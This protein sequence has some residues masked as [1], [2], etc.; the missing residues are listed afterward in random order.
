MSKA[1][2]PKRS[3]PFT[4]RQRRTWVL[5]IVDQEPI[6]H[7]ALAAYRR[8]GERV[9]E[10]RETVER[11]Q[12]RERPAFGSWL[13]ATFGA[14]LTEL[15][16]TEARIHQQGPL[17]DAI[18]FTAL[19][20]GCSPGEAYDEVMRDK[21]AHERRM[22]RQ[23][24]GEPPEEQAEADEA[25]E[26]FGPDD[27]FVELE[28]ELTRMFG[29]APPQANSKQ[30]PPDDPVPPGKP[31]GAKGRRKFS[32][33]VLDPTPEQDTAERRLKAAYRAVV[34]QLHP[35]LRSE[36]NEYEMQLWHDAQ[37][38]Y[39]RGDAEHLE[40]ILAVSELAATGTLPVGIGLGGLLGLVRQREASIQKLE[41][42]VRGLKKDPAW[43]FTRLASQEKLARRVGNRLRQD[44]AAARADLAAIEADLERCRQAPRRPK[45][46]SSRRRKTPP[47]SKRKGRR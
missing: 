23:A 13:A 16:E 33:P 9:Q 30:K 35:D 27:P 15:R 34:R 19:F 5:V 26:D 1:K 10:L 40:T 2:L 37:S 46:T 41:W 36:T 21:A 6:R 11:F 32:R 24:A 22:A 42:Q 25:E 28:A 18:R 20:S 47:A 45:K 3:T 29:F 12:T 17:L 38:A 8:A 39:A 31:P 43:N 7:E 14:L 44:V 4:A